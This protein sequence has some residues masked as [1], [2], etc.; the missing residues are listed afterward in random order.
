MKLDEVTDEGGEVETEF[1]QSQSIESKGDLNK[2]CVDY[3]LYEC[4]CPIK[5][6]SKAGGKK[7]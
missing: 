5:V 7:N 1:G 4:H 2:K 6:K 3:G